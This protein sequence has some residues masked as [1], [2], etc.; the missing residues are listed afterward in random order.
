MAAEIWAWLL[1]VV[2]STG[3]IGIVAFLMRNTIATFFS[4]AVEH[5][6]DKKLESFKADIRDNEKELDQ[7]RT[8]LASSRRER[9]S[10]IQSKRLEAAETLLRA[11]HALSQFTM[12]VEYMKILNGEQ[13]L[14]N[15]DDPKL[16]K[17]IEALIKP[18]D[19]DEKIKVVG[20]I[21]MTVPR[22]YLS[23]KS[24]RLFDAYEKTILQAAMMMKLYSLPLRDKGSLIKN[25]TL[26]EI[27]ME[28]VPS[29][30]KGFDK[31]GEE[32]AY[33]W[34]TYFHDAILRSLRHEVSGADEVIRDTE[35]IERLALDS[36]R[37]Q[38][39]IRSSL[40]EAGLPATLIK[41]DD[42][43]EASS[44]VAENAKPS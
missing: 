44:S 11:R 41:S 9:D 8:F 12:L 40:E 19:V 33:H 10:A 35:S 15:G 3:L 37:A 32:Y 1:S 5:R 22:L 4:K 27:V 2:S 7:I 17:F 30:K 24:L 18:F 36:R 29:S 21:D 28:L 43:A 14:Q 6:F 23:D 20:T 39:N 16:T 25:G 26:S 34:A 38:I 42:S 31:W 13:I